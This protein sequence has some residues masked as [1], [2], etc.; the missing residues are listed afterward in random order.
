MKQLILSLLLAS[1]V[2]LQAQIKINE[3]SSA[4]SALYPDE[5]SGYEDWIELFNAGSADVNLDGYSLNRQEA[6]ANNWKF[7]A[8]TIPSHQF[9]TVFASGKDHKPVIDHW[10]HVIPSGGIWEYKP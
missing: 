1:A 7:P 8:V 3:V 5:T 4:N 6:T 10:E 2:S 9:L